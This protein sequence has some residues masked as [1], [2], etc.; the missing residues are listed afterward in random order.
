[1]VLK[2]PS[3]EIVGRKLF[4]DSCLPNG[5][6]RVLDE[7]P[8]LLS[9]R[10][11]ISKSTLLSVSEQARQFS[12]RR[13]IPCV[14]GGGQRQAGTSLSF[15]LAAVFPA[16]VLACFSWL[17]PRVRPFLPVPALNYSA[18][19]SCVDPL[20]TSAKASVIFCPCSKRFLR[21]SLM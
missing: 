3:I 10:L 4:F 11:N 8:S 15:F 6:V 9:S 7:G 21:S 16:D 14:H 20:S 17:R 2:S 19:S 5:S 1:M 12:R 13:Y 18:L